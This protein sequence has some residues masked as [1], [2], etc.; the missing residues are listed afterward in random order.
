MTMTTRAR[1]RTRTLDSLAEEADAVDN[2]RQTAAE[3]ALSNRRRA[4][5]STSQFRGF[6]ARDP[7]T[8]TT[9]RRTSASVPRNSVPGDLYADPDDYPGDD[10]PGDD[11][12]D[13]D[14]DDDD[15]DPDWVDA[16]DDLDPNLAVLNNLAVAVNNLS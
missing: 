11:P 13:D 6:T 12:G 15:E 14:D 9:P 7:P 1:T 5:A 8:P 4:P 3:Q 2:L 10:G 16:V